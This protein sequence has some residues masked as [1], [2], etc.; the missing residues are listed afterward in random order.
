MLTYNHYWF[1]DCQFP[2]S[3]FKTKFERLEAFRPIRGLSL[4]T[5][6]WCQLWPDIC[7]ETAKKS[8]FVLVIGLEI[9][10]LAGERKEW[11]AQ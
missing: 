11:F 9:I 8:T 1:S 7:R 3:I 5:E 6:I 4:E 10:S 2:V